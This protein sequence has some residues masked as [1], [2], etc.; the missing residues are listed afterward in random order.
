MRSISVGSMSL[1]FPQALNVN[2][3][4]VV[5]GVAILVPRAFADNELPIRPF[6]E[7]PV[8]GTRRH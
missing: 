3:V 4:V 8:F 1:G 7:L 2:F 5:I 6:E